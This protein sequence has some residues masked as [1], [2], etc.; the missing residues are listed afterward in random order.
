METISLSNRQT[1]K[2]SSRQTA[3]RGKGK[4]DA[5]MWNEVLFNLCEANWDLRELCAVAAYLEEGKAPAD[6]EEFIKPRA[7]KRGFGPGW[8]EVTIA[9]VYHHVNYAWNCRHAG[10][11]RAIRCSDRDFNRWEKF[12]KD[13][14]ELW[15]SAERWEGKWPKER[16]AEHGWRTVRAAAMRPEF[17]AAEDALG[18]LIDGVFLRLGDGLDPIRRRP[19]K[20]REDAWAVSEADFGVLVRRFYCHFNAA[21]NV[22]RC[23]T[24]GGEKRGKE[25]FPR[26][27]V[28][29]WPESGELPKFGGRV[30]ATKNTKKNKGGEK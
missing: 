13:W 27:M 11:E 10:A 29:F 21:W 12:P 24:A 7:R 3:S 22:R 25:L 5:A 4:M 19:E 28:R 26:E 15:P 14:P 6:W 16:W 18:L 1:L 2:L 23:R 17:E 30:L 8:F 20:L 9:H